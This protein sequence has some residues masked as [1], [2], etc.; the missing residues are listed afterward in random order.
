MKYDISVKKQYEEEYGFILSKLPKKIGDGILSFLDENSF[1]H[2][3]EIRIHKN[4]EVCLMADFKNVKTNITAD[5]KDMEEI[6]NS[7]CEGSVYAHFDTIKDG[8]ISIGRGIRAGICGRAVCKNGEITGVCEIN[9]V[10]IRIPRMIY[11]ASEKIFEIL[12]KEDFAV[13]LLIYSAPGVGKTTI[14]RDLIYQLGK[15]NIQKRISVID[16]REEITTCMKTPA[17]TDVFISYPKGIGIELATKSMTP[18]IIICDEIS[19]KNEANAILK[20]VHGGVRLIATAHAKDFFELKSK[21][22]L[23]PLISS[24][25]FDYAIGV[26]R[27]YGTDKYEYEINELRKKDHHKGGNGMSLARRSI[28]TTSIGD[29][30]K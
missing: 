17:N 8:Y 19:S 29:T 27:K 13:S 28:F 20:A 18:E 10:N 11:N 30:G 16:T 25:V 1:K 26:S 3:N 6:L 14:L 4:S 2:M 21:D 9:S 24:G 7:L 15:E 23:I 5:E 12:K 22:I